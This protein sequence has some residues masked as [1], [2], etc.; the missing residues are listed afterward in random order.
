MVEGRAGFV[1]VQLRVRWCLACRRYKGPSTVTEL[2]ANPKYWGAATAVD[3][4][5]FIDAERGE[6]ESSIIL[7]NIFPKFLG[8]GVVPE[9]QSPQRF[10]SFL[11]GREY[12]FSVITAHAELRSSGRRVDQFLGL[13]M[14]RTTVLARNIHSAKVV[15]CR[16]LG[17]RTS[18]FRKLLTGR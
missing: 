8:L 1:D 12:D 3:R 9:K 17:I 5:I 13:P 10:W 15:T 18:R 7:R 6:G 4:A 14:E 11:Q 2:S 16:R